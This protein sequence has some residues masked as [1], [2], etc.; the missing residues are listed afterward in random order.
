MDSYYETSCNDSAI[1]T[2]SLINE[3]KASTK[4]ELLVACANGPIMQINSTQ[5]LKSETKF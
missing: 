2:D 5:K 4:Q 3:Y 1:D